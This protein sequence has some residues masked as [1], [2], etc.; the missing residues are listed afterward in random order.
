MKCPM[1][2]T[3]AVTVVLEVTEI[4]TLKKVLACEIAGGWGGG[5]GG[6][7]RSEGGVGE[8]LIAFK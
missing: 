3:L 5:G 1:D 7:R 8:Q 6:G 4:Q 2:L